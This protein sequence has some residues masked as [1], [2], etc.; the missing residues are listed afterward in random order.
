[1]REKGTHVSVEED[2][3]SLVVL[4]IHRG[5]WR[6]PKEVI[7]RSLEEIRLQIYKVE[8]ALVKQ[9]LDL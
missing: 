1:M 2:E 7:E 4:T 3:A 6:W 8:V 9:G 5:H